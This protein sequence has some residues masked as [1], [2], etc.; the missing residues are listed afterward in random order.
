MPPVSLFGEGGWDVVA[1]ATP[2][3]NA[4]YAATG[5]APVNTHYVL[6]GDLN[7]QNDFLGGGADYLISGVPFQAHDSTGL[8]GGN[9]AAIAAPIMP[10]GLGALVVAPTSGF[11]VYKLN[12]TVTYGP[13]SEAHPAPPNGT[14][15]TACP[16]PGCPPINVPDLNLVAMVDS[17][18]GTYQQDANGNQW[19]DDYW[20]NPAVYGT[21][22]QSVLQYD[23]A[24]GDSVVPQVAPDPITR[25]DPNDEN[26]YFERWAAAVAPSV[27]KYPDAPSEF[28]PLKFADEFQGP[29]LSSEVGLIQQEGGIGGFGG[30]GAIALVPPSGL[31]D[32]YATETAQPYSLTNEPTV[33][34]WIG[35]QNA[36]GDFVTPTPAA[37]EAGVDAG[38]AAGEAACSPTN[39]N[40]LY[41]ATNKVPG[42]YPLTWVDCLYAPT[43]GLSMAKTNALAGYIRYLVTDGQSVLSAYGDATLPEQYVFQALNAAN[44]VVTANCPS[45]GGVV[46]LTSGAVPYAPTDPG[47]QSVGAVDECET[48]PTPPASTTT[49]TTTTGTVAATGSGTAS[50]SGTV[51]S[52]PITGSAAPPAAQNSSQVTATTTVS[53]SSHTASSSS[54]PPAG[55]KSATAVNPPSGAGQ[56]PTGSPTATA[57]NAQP[58][59][60]VAANLPE[61]LPARGTQTLDRLT[62]LVLGGGLFFLA[63]AIWR[64]VG[65]VART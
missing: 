27:W 54:K 60:I 58:Q 37:V 53:G 2:W 21:W 48:A 18:A 64:K 50:G 47:V 15:P 65:W 3:H 10:S 46:V 30:G 38:A 25:S 17:Y 12:S 26:Y 49:T 33:A 5:A 1:E 62:A 40:A 13:L 41:A 35:V 19:A 9:V 8:P 44:Q 61:P 39:Q 14:P 51:T 57:A 11:Q 32:L 24:E 31:S 28:L 22:D 7:A 63:R 20:S 16:A 34:Q 23:A 55:P 59:P 43:K 36:N 45:A 42:A 29:G 6:E 52:T 4:M 56:T